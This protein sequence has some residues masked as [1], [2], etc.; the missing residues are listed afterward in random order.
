[1]RGAER[2]H[3]APKGLV[4]EAVPHLVAELDCQA[5]AVGVQIRLDERDDA[6]SQ[7]AVAPL[8]DDRSPQDD[9]SPHIGMLEQGFL[10]LGQRHELAGDADDG[11]DARTRLG[12]WCAQ[13]CE[14]RVYFIVSSSHPRRKACSETL[15]I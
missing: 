6:D 14:D 4:G 7:R 10:D 15:A 1:V 12:G 13:Q 2:L 3:G 11:V 8:R 9:R 5:V